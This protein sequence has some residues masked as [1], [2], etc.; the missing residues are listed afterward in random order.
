[1]ICRL[2]EKDESRSMKIKRLRKLVGQKQPSLTKIDLKAKMKAALTRLQEK[3]KVTRS[4]KII[5]LRRKATVTVPQTKVN[6]EVEAK[7]VSE[8]EIEPP[9]ETNAKDWLDLNP[10]G[11]TRLFV[12]NLNFA[13]TEK[14]LKE[15][16]RNC[17]HVLFLKDKESGQFYGSGFVEMATAEDAARVSEMNGSKFLDRALKISF[18]PPQP[19]QKWPPA[20][21]Y[22][23]RPYP[24]YGCKKIF[25]G[26][27]A[28][29]ATDEDFAG[30]FADCGETVEMRW[31][32]DQDTGD[33]KGCGFIEFATPEGCK[34]AGEL[35][36]V[37]V[38]GR[39]IRIDWAE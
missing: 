21:K 37:K 3:G 13:V 12:G 33:F 15:H 17:T 24:G 26:N 35:S 10:K 7:S 31:L 1:M 27:I 16:L 36:G 29:E 25:I 11:I 22:S 23:I 4:G 20:N 19:G 30:I 6:P 38:K 39:Q 2:L 9:A 14:S 28:F 5:S 18:A 34:K 8:V 32:S